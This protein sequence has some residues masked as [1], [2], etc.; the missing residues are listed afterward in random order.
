MHTVRLLLTASLLCG[1]ATS[2][3]AQGGCA[4]GS[5]GKTLCGPPDS[6][7]IVERTGRVVCSPTGG[8]IAQDRYGEAVCGPGAC[9]KD[10]RGDFF[11]SNAPKGAAQPDM[12]GNVACSGSCV[13]ARADACVRPD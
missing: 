9:A 8:G 10:L 1:F 5:N 11:C 6:H 7:C 13:A 12:H 2:A 4:T 3:L